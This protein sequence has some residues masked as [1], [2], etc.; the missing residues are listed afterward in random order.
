LDRKRIHLPHG[1][2]LSVCEFIELIEARGEQGREFSSKVNALNLGYRRRQRLD[3]DFLGILDGDKKGVHRLLAG[4]AA[5]AV[6]RHDPSGIK[7]A[8]I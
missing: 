5:P 2:E 6:A 3:Y 1:E 8:E 7:S 4:R